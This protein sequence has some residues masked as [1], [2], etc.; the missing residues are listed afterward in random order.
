[1]PGFSAVG[2]AGS[3]FVLGPVF[4]REDLVTAND[5]MKFYVSAWRPIGKNTLL[6]TFTLHLPSGMAIKNVMLH[7]KGA[8][9]W[10]QLP[11]S[12]WL[13]DGKTQY[14]H[15]IDF[16]SNAAKERFHELA[17]QAVKKHLNEK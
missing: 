12:E 17:M 11:A 16:D 9:R 4:Y 14:A 6:A 3:G 5:I 13:R 8:K 2:G 1:M 7:E 10:I 15:L